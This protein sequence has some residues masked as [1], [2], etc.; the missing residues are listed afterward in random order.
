MSQSCPA[1]PPNQAHQ[2]REIR[3]HHNRHALAHQPQEPNPPAQN[4]DPTPS[5]PE[6]PS[7]TSTGSKSAAESSK[8]N[9][10]GP[11]Q[12]GSKCRDCCECQLRPS[13]HRPHPH[14]P[15]P[16]RGTTSRSTHLVR[17]TI[18]HGPWMPGVQSPTSPAA[19]WSQAEPHPTLHTHSRAERRPGEP[20]PHTQPTRATTDT[21]PEEAQSKARRPWRPD[22]GRRNLHIHAH[23]KRQPGV[24]P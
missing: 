5:R 4:T 22:G 8:D 23:P 11:V 1:C 13:H 2:Q 19:T 6:A 9:R 18:A 16:K 17:A 12:T 14:A 3:A 7:Q 21:G 24:V 10:Q 15:K 20:D